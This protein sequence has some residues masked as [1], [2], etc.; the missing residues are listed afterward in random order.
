MDLNLFLKAII[1]LFLAILFLQSGIDKIIDWK[2]NLEW[3]TG[4]FSKSIFKSQVPMM[5]GTMTLI[6]NLSGLLNLI[7][8]YFLL[9]EN[10]ALY[11]I[12]GL[13]L[14]ALSITMLF[15]GQRI[16]KDYEGAATLVI[17]FTLICFGIFIHS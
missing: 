9:F 4:H 8:I 2:G 17:Y 3:L 14:S 5:L 6:E 15:F 13:M 11:A 1:S 12:Y 16:A 7:A 10:N